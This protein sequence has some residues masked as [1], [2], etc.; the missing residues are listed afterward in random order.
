MRVNVENLELLRL[1]VTK[2]GFLTHKDPKDINM[3]WEWEMRFN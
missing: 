2:F 3:I 1:Q